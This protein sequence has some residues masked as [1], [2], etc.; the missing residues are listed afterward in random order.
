MSIFCY[1]W[2][3]RFESVFGIVLSVSACRRR[4]GCCRRS[5]WSGRLPNSWNGCCRSNWSGCRQN[6]WSGNC[7][8][9]SLRSRNFCTKNWKNC[10]KSGWKMSK[11]GRNC[12]CCCLNFC[13]SSRRSG[14]NCRCCLNFCRKNWRTTS[15][16]GWNSNRTRTSGRRSCRK[17]SGP[18]CRM[19]W[20]R[21]VR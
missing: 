8:R 4:N 16:D 2:F 5:N 21:N 17:K 14:M 7:C 6:N 15:R 11:A 1:A 12:R 9:N 18:C 20:R 3:C 19:R 13:R 10:R